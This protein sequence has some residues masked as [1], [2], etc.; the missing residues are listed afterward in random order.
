MNYFHLKTHFPECFFSWT[1]SV[2]G[3]CVPGPV[4]KPNLCFLSSPK[5]A[6]ETGLERNSLPGGARFPRAQ[7]ASLSPCRALRRA[8]LDYL[9]HAMHSQSTH[10]MKKRLQPPAVAIRTDSGVAAGEMRSFLSVFQLDPQ[11]VQSKN[12]HMDVIEM[13]GVR[14]PQVE[15]WLLVRA[16]LRSAVAFVV[17]SKWSSP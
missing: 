7:P 4:A 5:P 11:T 8:G 6:G 16:E 14:L 10:P 2:A 12:W 1:G 15:F 9:K 17:R 13:N 3:S